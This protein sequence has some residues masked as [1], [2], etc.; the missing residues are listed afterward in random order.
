MET[1]TPHTPLTRLAS[2]LALGFALALALVFVTAATWA[3]SR[4]R[5]A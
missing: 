1:S 4:A 5:G 3:I 2:R